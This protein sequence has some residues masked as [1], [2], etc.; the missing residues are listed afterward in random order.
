MIYCS[1][2]KQ[3]VKK[4]HKGVALGEDDLPR[5]FLLLLSEKEAFNEDD[6]VMALNAYTGR[7]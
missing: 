6:F 7:L 4:L 5:N 2:T 3:G 1:L